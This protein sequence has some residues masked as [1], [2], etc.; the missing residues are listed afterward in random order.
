MVDTRDIAEAAAVELL[1]PS[2]RPIRC[3]ERR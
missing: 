1:R 3:P 2:E